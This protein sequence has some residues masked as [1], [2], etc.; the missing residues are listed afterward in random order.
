MAGVE[1]KNPEEAVR[2]LEGGRVNEMAGDDPE[3]MVLKRVKLG[4]AS[5]CVVANILELGMEAEAGGE[6]D[7]EACVLCWMLTKVLKANTFKVWGATQNLGPRHEQTV[8]KKLSTLE[9]RW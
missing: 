5:A 6:H 7:G 9:K 8:P 1:V 2:N 4:E 3:G